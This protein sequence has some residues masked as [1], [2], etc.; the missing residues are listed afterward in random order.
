M[1][2]VVYVD[3]IILTGT[4]IKEIDSL[5]VFL[6]EKFRIKD[7]GRLHYFLGL[8]ILYRQDGGLISQ[9]KFTFDLL[10]EF[11][12][13]HDRPTTSPLDSTEKLK[14]TEG[15]LLSDSTHY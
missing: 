12:S 2:V 14:F 13:M 11:N 7:L 9:R 15:T 1:F 6:H 8:E 5:K 3:D 10:K 4:D